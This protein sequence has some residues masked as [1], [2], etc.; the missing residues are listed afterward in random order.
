MATCASLLPT[1]NDDRF[2]ENAKIFKS[3]AAGCLR[4][5]DAD[6]QSKRFEYSNPNL[7]RRREQMKRILTLL[8]SIIMVLGMV[9][10]TMQAEA[11]ESNNTNATMIAVRWN[12]IGFD[13]YNKPFTNGRQVP[14]QK[15]GQEIWGRGVY[16]M[17]NA[18]RAVFPRPDSIP[19][20]PAVPVYAVAVP[21]DSPDSTAAFLWTEVWLTVVGDAG[22]STYKDHW[23][24]IMDSIGQVWFDSDGT[25]NDCRFYGYADPNDANYRGDPNSTFDNCVDNPKA[26]VD[27]VVSNNTQ[28]PY[29]FDPD[30]NPFTNPATQGLPNTHYSI[31][32]QAN[33]KIAPIYEPRV[34]FWDAMNT[35]RL[36]KLGWADMNDYYAYSTGTAFAHR[37]PN[38]AIPSGV[39][40]NGGDCGYREET[41]E[42]GHCR[43]F[44]DWDIGLNLRDFTFNMGTNNMAGNGSVLHTE[45]ISH[46]A[47]DAWMTV[48]PATST[49]WFEYGEFIYEKSGNNSAVVF[50]GAPL[51]NRAVAVTDEADI[52]KTG[53]IVT[54]AGITRSYAPNTQILDA[55]PIGVYNVGDDFDVGIP[56]WVFRNTALDGVSFTTS[57]NE[58]YHDQ[59]ISGL[60]NNNYD[61]GEFIYQD[62]NNDFVVNGDSLRDRVNVRLNNTAD[63]RLTNVNGLQDNINDHNPAVLSD[64]R[65]DTDGLIRAGCAPGD[66]LLMAE[67]LDGGCLSPNYDIAVESDAWIGWDDAGIWM[68]IQPSMTIAGIRS[69]FDTTIAHAE[70]VNK[71][72]VL[73]EKAMDFMPPACIFHDVKFEE[74]QFGGWSVWLDDGIDNNRMPNANPA[75]FTRALDLSANIYFDQTSEQYVGTESFDKWDLDYGRGSENDLF[76]NIVPFASGDVT[77]ARYGFVEPSLPGTPATAVFGCGHSIY[78]DNDMNLALIGNT[79]A[80]ANIAI[81]GNTVTVASIAGF[82]IGERI[83]IEGNVPAEDEYA[84]ILGIAGNVITFDVDPIG[85]PL[86]VAFAHTF[87]FNIY[88]VGGSGTVSKGDI[89]CTDVYVT[90]NGVPYFYPAGSIVSPGDL[91]A[92]TP[93]NP[94]TITYFRESPGPG[95]RLYE[96]AFY[97]LPNPGNDLPLN[98][99]YDPG[100]DIYFV[101]VGV[102]EIDWRAVRMSTVRLQDKVYECGTPIQQQRLMWVD[103]PVRMISMGS[104]GNQQFMDFEVLPGKIQIDVKIDQPLMVEQTS[105]IEVKVSPPPRKPTDKIY[106]LIENL[107][108]NT[109]NIAETIHVIDTNNPVI[110]LE[111]TPYRGSCDLSGFVQDRKV[112]I[113]AFQ[114]VESA[115]KYAKTTL[116]VP[117]DGPYFDPYWKKVY[118][119]PEKRAYLNW[120]RNVIDP[121]NDFRYSIYEPLLGHLSNRYDC[122]DVKGYTVAPENIVITAN[123][124]CL[125]TLEQR[126]PNLV[127]TLTDFDNPNDVNDPANIRFA[128]PSIADRPHVVNYNAKGAGISYLFTAYNGAAGGDR[129]QY[130]VQVNDDDTFICWQ[131]EDYEP[132]GVLSPNDYLF[133]R[134]LNYAY[135]PDPRMGRNIPVTN[136]PGMP[137][138]ATD[139]EPE[140][141]LA[142]S[143]L[144]DRDCSGK[145]ATCNICGE[146]QGFM[147]IGAVTLNDLYGNDQI[148]QGIGNFIIMTFGVPT[149]V[150]DYGYLSTTDPGGQMVVAVQPRDTSS[151][152]WIR[153][154]SDQT[155]FNYNSVDGQLWPPNGPAFLQDGL[156]GGADY[157]GVIRFK[158]LPPDPDVNFCE[159]NMV[160]HALQYSRANY[161][162]GSDSDGYHTDPLH[163]LGLPA[164]QI[165]TPYNPII[166]DYNNEVRCYPGGQ[167]HPGRL[168]GTNLRKSGWNAYPAIHAKQFWKLGTEFFPLTDY[169]LFFVLK[170]QRGEHLSFSN[171]QDWNPPYPVREDLRISRI[172]IEGPF[173]RPRF[174]NADN[175]NYLA[176]NIYNGTRYLPIQYDFN[177]KLVIDSSNAAAFSQN[178]L[179]F[180]A[181]QFRNVTSPYLNLVNPKRNSIQYPNDTSDPLIPE[182]RYLQLLDRSLDFTQL[183]WAN[184]GPS[185]P[186]G[187]NDLFIIDEI[188]PIN[189]GNLKITVE[190]ASG[191]RKIYQDCCQEPPVDGI[192]INGL[193]IQGA[194]KEILVDQDNV[195]EVSLKEHTDIQFETSCND[196]LMY[197]WQ[198][199]GVMQPGAIIRYG[200]GDG[201]VTKPPRNSNYVNIGWSYNPGDDINGDNKITF[202]HFETE[203]LGTYDMTTNTWK[204]GVIDARTYQR[205]DGVY[206]FELTESNGAF[207]DEV[208]FD[209]GGGSV[210]GG[211]FSTQDKVISQW[212]ELPIY[213]TAYKYGDDDNDRSFQPFYDIP[214]ETVFG[215]PGFS[216]E[217]YLAAQAAVKVVGQEDLVVETEP[218]ILTAGVTPEYVEGQPLTFIIKKQDGVTAFNFREEGVPNIA[219]DFRITDDKWIW[220]NLFDDPHPDDPETYGYLA[221]LPQFYWL[222]TDLH[223]FDNTPYNNNTF[224][225]PRANPFNP[226]AID[227]NDA[228]N[229][230]YKFFGFCANDEGQFPL[231][232]W[233]PD[234]KHR[235]KVDVKVKP[236]KVEYQITNVDDPDMK[237]FTN[238][239]N[240]DFVMTAADN[241]L[242]EVR[243]VCRTQDGGKL[244]TGTAKG[245]SVCA[246]SD[247]DVARFTPFLS[248]PASFRRGALPTYNIGTARGDVLVRDPMP[249]G[250]DHYENARTYP[251]LG[252]DFDNDGKLESTNREVM[253][254]SYGRYA[255]RYAYY[256]NW[257][258]WTYFYIQ[259]P[260]ETLVINGPR[261]VVHYNTDNSAYFDPGSNGLVY[262]VFK[263]GDIYV[264]PFS[265]FG[266]GAGC[267]YNS[268]KKAGYVMA[269]LDNNRIINFA[270]ALSLDDKGSTKFY[271]FAE[272]MTQLT[273]LVG[274]NKWTNTIFGDTYGGLFSYAQG[275]VTTGQ[276]V[277]WY[278]YEHQLPGDRLAPRTMKRRYGY[279]PIST[280]MQAFIPAS[281]NTYALDW[282][283]FPANE[284]VAKILSPSVSVNNASTRQVLNKNLMNPEAFDI[285]YGKPNYLQFVFSP[286]DSRDLALDTD[287]YII[288]WP[289]FGG[290]EE[291]F[292]AAKTERS[293]I[294]P[295][296]TECMAVITPTG[297][298]FRALQIHYYAR[299]KRFVFPYE[300]ILSTGLDGLP[301]LSQFD[302]V[303]GLEVIVESEDLLRAQITGTL[304]ITVREVGS[305][306][307]AAQAELKIE[308]AGVALP[309]KR[310][311]DKGQ[312]TVVVTPTET[313]VIK[314]KATLTGYAEGEG[315]I[316]VG[317]DTQPPELTIES[318]TDY[319]V[320]NSATVQ[321]K[322]KTKPGSTLTVNGQKTGI[323]ISG[324]F[325]ANVSLNNGANVIVIKSSSPTGA[326]TTR[327]LTVI[328]D[329]TPPMVMMNKPTHVIANATTYEVTGRVEPGSKVTVNGQPA[330]VVFD[331]W[332]AT[333]NLVP[334]SNTITIVAVDQAGNQTTHTETIVNYN[335]TV[336]EFVNGNTIA[337]VNGSPQTM[338]QAV[339]RSAAN[340]LM[341]PVT[342]F[343]GFLGGTAPAGNTVTINID[344]VT[345]TLTVGLTSATING[346]T[347]TLPDAPVMVGNAVMVPAEFLML[348]ISDEMVATNKALPADID[349]NDPAGRLTITFY[350]IP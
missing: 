159:L 87:P 59:I 261:I 319:A 165:Q 71:D 134:F 321:I 126:F 206:K 260:Y 147:P 315:Y 293:E 90:Y 231:F 255:N 340:S 24:V 186:G 233:S 262:N 194:P 69:G 73:G 115:E 322:G 336:V 267:I 37:G 110:N 303:R 223:N 335:K 3:D 60:G 104:N 144:I 349:W 238:P 35:K 183:H 42:G 283:A 112:Y 10:F 230:K 127:L 49:P 31:P 136:V 285:V 294:N 25:F 346:K 343:I 50:P 17:P 290:K 117:Q 297:V 266:W 171:I 172:I 182:N 145:Q 176:N 109:Y 234:R 192:K 302:A 18:W 299:N 292:I 181:G 12:R 212:E 337:N 187:A 132:L 188:I 345:M 296:A 289:D 5:K 225:S 88:E 204:A 328:R 72:A 178:A 150:T 250:I 254:S 305:N 217:V 333:V 220:N 55:A 252:F 166:Y 258:G 1:S 347:I 63:I 97:D 52:R 169:G 82:A 28:G 244:L 298:S 270:D 274:D 226:I 229:G 311:N 75:A 200:A 275:L 54:R 119:D 155:V 276:N 184:I 149:M 265:T 242:Y 279:R 46:A 138:L 123:R 185:Q 129:I 198:D 120:A 341:V 16:G 32:Y 111:L 232:I 246:G 334:G 99:M 248:T 66:L 325:T 243:V 30:Y 65:F 139:S 160:D 320:V 45:N 154:T 39:V 44:A 203:I 287:A 284:N 124:Q 219:G 36:W 218:S 221:E 41:R 151:D 128:T 8:I 11:A 211:T 235:A 20:P 329:T 114:D 157:C 222:R 86:G 34:Y 103:N 130:I 282:D 47:G 70:M 64:M 227:F 240:P 74:R 209:F 96:V 278:A 85:A 153:V 193:D 78:K 43:E 26:L 199:R 158:I 108:R 318:P 201:W 100:E 9:P 152:L 304:N 40:Y 131:W 291:F 94:R 21:K 323:E 29:I 33:N 213:I 306:A 122:Y 4:P 19:I 93:G 245:V 269:D 309:S 84:T 143:A 113:H 324:A 316:T 56:L 15:T 23:Y 215:T 277:Y 257:W 48:P 118:R 170:N 281:D 58:R 137:R 239:G 6:L 83:L 307:P 210:V 326:S 286:S 273:G 175:T 195:I 2:F 38:G 197:C 280:N 241:R 163:R 249:E 214:P 62:T 264:D 22:R 207:I 339:R 295:A 191:K 224:F 342:E 310:C 156:G 13:R 61:P 350:Q 91:D 53:V 142:K 189:D 308:G 101:P 133:Y 121:V 81:G 327:Y 216:H 180:F 51:F 14:W 116:V 314:V 27:P 140:A 272:D 98:N 89:R 317:V 148:A 256:Y 348:A 179:N 67:V 271:I 162:V 164:P 106:I 196:A 338:S 107:P 125:T 313:G 177:Q 251:R 161:T 259:P 80:T 68:P 236:P 95:G 79:Q 92:S 205:Q 141:S 105:H 312:A 330:T 301:L 288:V 202:N 57:T 7:V 331:V 247:K 174:M 237:V 300:Y 253:R 332:A 167:T 77:G 208:G 263:Q 146:E 173:M 102:R 344:G 190:M 76:G 135:N 268:N 228:E 168:E